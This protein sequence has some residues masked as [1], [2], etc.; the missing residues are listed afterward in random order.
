MV[1]HIHSVSFSR[2]IVLVIL[3]MICFTMSMF[4]SYPLFFTSSSV[5]SYILWSDFVTK[6][7]FLEF[8]PSLFWIPMDPFQRGPSPLS[9]TFLELSFASDLT[10]TTLSYPSHS[11]HS[12][13]RV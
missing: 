2:S 4:P 5:K 1:Y 8:N 11:S 12:Q 3:H 6:N 9:V 13:V 10:L 7:S